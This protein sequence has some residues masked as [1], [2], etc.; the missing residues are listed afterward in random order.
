VRNEKRERGIKPAGNADDDILHPDAL[1][2][3]GESV[4]LFGENFGGITRKR[5]GGFPP[6]R[7][8]AQAAEFAAGFQIIFEYSS[9]HAVNYTK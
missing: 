8:R 5:G 4:D 9:V 1:E 6:L 3:H 7:H 2:P